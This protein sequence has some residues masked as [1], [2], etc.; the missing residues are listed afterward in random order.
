MQPD[1]HVESSAARSLMR[2]VDGREYQVAV[3]D[4]GQAEIV[5]FLQL[6]SKTQSLPSADG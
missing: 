2:R 1:V 3:D 4:S 6:D 5:D